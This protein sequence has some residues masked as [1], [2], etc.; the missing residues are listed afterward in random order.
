MAD[1]LICAGCGATVPAGRPRCGR[2]G[3]RGEEP[4][5]V[6]P[7]GRRSWPIHVLIVGTVFVVVAVAAVGTLA[8]PRRV[9]QAESLM[10]I[11][12]SPQSTAQVTAAPVVPLPAP[13]F[14]GAESSRQGIASYNGGDMTAA[15]AQFTAAVERD[16][17]SADA[18]NNLGQALVRTGRAREAIP[19]FDR[20]IAIADTVWAYHFN[21]ARAY[22]ELKEWRQAIAGYE[23]AARL[24]PDDYVTQFNL[25]RARQADGAMPGALEAYARAA[26]LAPGQ[27][28]FHLAYGLALDQSGKPREAV[29]EFRRF[30]ELDPNGSQAEKVRIRLAELGEAAG[31][32]S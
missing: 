26:E 10:P 15:V 20:A 14:A 27:A 8:G 29:V 4:K 11:A 31:T 21:R 6:E 22:G 2:C 23:D 17:N 13:A 12:S 5:F 1:A 18:L 9:A 30:L 16:P 7:V 25:G 32:S 24:F 28:D 19:Y 3:A